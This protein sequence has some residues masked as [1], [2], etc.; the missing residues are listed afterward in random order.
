[1]RLP[2]NLPIQRKVMLIVLV[3]CTLSLVVACTIL[4]VYELVTF[5]RD[6]RNDLSTL[7]AIVANSVAEDV[8]L[9]DDGAVDM[10]LSGLQARRHVVGATITRDGEIFASFGTPEKPA[11]LSRYGEDGGQ[12][13]EGN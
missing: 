1:M 2:R 13:F 5:R 12:R 9:R 7:T 8:A 10:I 3:T 11:L 4:F 6:F